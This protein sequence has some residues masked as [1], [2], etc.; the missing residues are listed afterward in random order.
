M[1]GGTFVTRNKVRAGAYI[2]F[3]SEYS[4]L[5]TVSDRGVVLLPMELPFGAVHEAVAVEG[6]TDVRK[7]FGV[8]ALSDELLMLREAAK[9]ASRVLVW[10]LNSGET[11]RKTD[12]ALTV[13]ARYPGSAGNTLAVKIVDP[14]DDS[15]MLH[16][17]TFLGEKLVDEQE[18]AEIGELEDN[19]WVLFSGEGELTVH[20]G[21]VL[22]G[23]TDEEVL[24]ED[25]EDF[26]LAAGRLTF[27]T[28][29]VPTG[30]S[31]IK[32]MAFSFVKRMRE[33]EGIKIQAVVSNM[34]ADYEGI[35]SV[36][37]GVILEDGTQL[38][39][40]QA[41]AYVAGMT[42]GAAVNKSCTYDR[43]D[44]A[45]E[46]DRHL[47]ASEIIALLKA[48]QFI[49]VQRVDKVIVEQDINTFTGFSPEKGDA[50]R[51]NRTLRVM[52]AIGTDVRTIFEDYYLGKC[53]NDEDGRALFREELFSYLSQL[54]EV[55]AV[56]KPVIEDI[57]VSRG[58]TADSVIVEMAV[59]P[60]DA[61]EKLYMTVTVGA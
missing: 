21:I 33:D 6:D 2:N 16:V 52:D 3:V 28:M 58:E 32:Q 26:F 23:G 53:A 20:A 56:E 42:A 61:M 11:A 39:A 54:Y 50:F 13:T 8:S 9:R 30:S 27:N 49:F 19:A 47:M 5:G 1:A 10:R 35:I 31:E 40:A 15:G 4:P 43:Y 57:V 36:C 41:T 55:R 14:E 25:W 12:T 7:L 17:Q 38:S 34:V 48:G 24:N 44:G 29:A 60:V 46:V 37:G 59:Q 51:K 18:A 22:E 45:A